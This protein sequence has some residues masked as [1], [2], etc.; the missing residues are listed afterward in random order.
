[1]E[2]GFQALLCGTVTIYL[3]KKSNKNNPYFRRKDITFVRIKPEN[4][5]RKISVKT[6]IEAQTKTS[7][8]SF[9]NLF[10]HLL[11]KKD[12]IKTHKK[13]NT[14]QKTYTQTYTHTHR[15][16]H[17]HTQTHTNTRLN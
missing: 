4:F 10:P 7:L 3:E 15:H 8:F 13:T 11:L 5:T 6:Y 2:N 14:Q 16:T 12:E 17:T 9:N 1:M